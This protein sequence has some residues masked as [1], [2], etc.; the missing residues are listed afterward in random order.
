VRSILLV[1]L[2]PATPLCQAFGRRRYTP[3]A[4][5]LAF[6]LQ[7]RARSRWLCAFHR[8]AFVDRMPERLSVIIAGFNSKGG[9]GKTTVAVN[10]APALAAPR[11]RV[12]LVDLD[13][14]SNASTWLGV[15]RNQ[16]R[17]SSASVLL[18]KY[19][20]VK[21]IRHTSTPHLDL[22]TGSLELANA[23]VALVSLRG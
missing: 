21:A 7:S 6:H 3:P 18:E 5:T 13:S 10:L 11:R 14:Q 16:L 4:T 20:I 17:P 2:T 23:D 15:S 19:P 8:A 1:V 22:L 9:G 12:L